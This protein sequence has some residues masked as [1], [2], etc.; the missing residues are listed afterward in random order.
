MSQRLR[1]KWRRADGGGG[2]RLGDPRG[3]E[4]TL[5]CPATASVHLTA[6]EGRVG[7]RNGTPLQEEP[8]TPWHRAEDR[9]QPFGKAVAAPSPSR[10]DAEA[11]RP[12]GGSGG[13]GAPRR[14]S[15]SPSGLEERRW[16]LS[17]ALWQ[18]TLCKKRGE[19]SVFV[20]GAGEGELG[21]GGV[22]GSSGFCGAACPVPAW[23]GYES[24]E[25][26]TSVRD[27]EGS[28]MVL[29]CKFLRGIANTDH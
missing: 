22:L 14:E 4:G 28:S 1:T 27:T 25:N 16:S 13:E 11:A 2:R 20:F 24:K 10:R 18:A 29:S 8:L 23:G 5:G 12:A 19:K 7:H 26:V 21:E 17:R 9:E 6:P 15:P 3:R